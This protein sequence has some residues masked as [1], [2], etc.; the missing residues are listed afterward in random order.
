[1]EKEH[2]FEKFNPK[3]LGTIS[4]WHYLGLYCK[5]NPNPFQNKQNKSRKYVP[6]KLCKNVWQMRVSK[7]SDHIYNSLYINNGPEAYISTHTYI[8]LYSEK[9][10]HMYAFIQQIFLT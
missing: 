3:I 7:A 4:E 2:Y 1:M 6:L 8:Q 9:M 5:R 10:E